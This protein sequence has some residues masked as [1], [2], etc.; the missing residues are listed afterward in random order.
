[1]TIANPV[2][3]RQEACILEPVCLFQERHD[4]VSNPK[5]IDIHLT[6]RKTEYFAVEVVSNV[7]MSL[8]MWV[9]AFRQAGR[10]A[11][12][13]DEAIVD[14]IASVKAFL[15]LSDVDRGTVMGHLVQCKAFDKDRDGIT[16]LGLM[17]VDVTIET[18]KRGFPYP[19]CGRQASASPSR[20]PR[21]G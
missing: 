7:S 16:G 17:K 1:M 3:K 11:S 18:A 5:E 21:T 10:G 9:R 14:S 8:A 19:L 6:R 13:H 2:G 4:R 20:S 15:E 12:D